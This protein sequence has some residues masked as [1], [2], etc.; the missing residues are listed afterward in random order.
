MSNPLAKRLP[1][2][3]RSIVYDLLGWTPFPAQ[4]P[5][6]SDVESFCLIFAGGVGASKTDVAEHYMLPEILPDAMRSVYLQLAG[7]PCEWNGKETKKTYWLVSP[8]YILQREVFTRLVDDLRTLG[9]RLESVNTPQDGSWFVKILDSGT[10]IASMSANQP[11]SMHSKAISGIIVDEA[12]LVPDFIRKERL[13]PRLTRGGSSDPW[14]F[15]SGT[16]EGMG[17]MASLYDV[18]QGPNDQGISSY[19]M[20]TWLNPI[21]FPDVTQETADWLEWYCHKLP[22]EKELADQVIELARLNREAPGLYLALTSMPTDSFAQRYGA[23]P[24][25][26]SGLVFPEFDPQKH[27]IHGLTFDPEREVEVWIDPGVQNPYAV[28]AV[29]FRGEIVEVVDELYYRQSSSEEMIRECIQRPWW[30]KVQT[31]QIDATQSE[32][33]AVWQRSELWTTRGL[34]P[35]YLRSQ[36]VLIDMGIE[37]TRLWLRQPGTNEIRLHVSDKCP[38]LIKEFG[39]YH[40]DAMK[41]ESDQFRAKP[42]DKNNHALTAL[43]YGLVG[44]FGIG[45]G[46]ERTGGKSFAYR[47]RF[48]TR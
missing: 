4:I 13:I 38:N 48:P 8:D 30:G 23:R 16:F 1:F 29:Q 14:L 22:S 35:P 7:I 25:R 10:E 33:R 17:G 11:N 20:P 47:P 27:I 40:W 37:R 15:M 19:A 42:V 36:K 24:Q 2:S 45:T 3:A 46:Y 39:L 9:V 26:P 31:G 21:S 28:L 34:T 32:Q 44:K 18:G 41:G 12:A 5:P 43:A 6:L